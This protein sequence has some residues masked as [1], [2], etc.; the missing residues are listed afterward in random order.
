MTATDNPG[1]DGDH[2]HDKIKPKVNE[3][4]AGAPNDGYDGQ[5][6]STGK[7]DGGDPFVWLTP[8]KHVK[9]SHTDG[10]RGQSQPKPS[11][12]GDNSVWLTPTSYSY[13]KK[14]SG[15]ATNDGYDGDNSVWLTPTSHTRVVHGVPEKHDGSHSVWLTPDKSNG[16]HWPTANTYDN[17]VWLTPDHTVD[18]THDHPENGDNPSNFAWLSPHKHDGNEEHDHGDP[19]HVHHIH[20]HKAYPGAP[21]EVKVYANEGMDSD[22]DDLSCPGDGED[23]A[24]HEDVEEHKVPDH[25]KEKFRNLNYIVH[26]HK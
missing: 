5:R 8:S 1:F 9:S 10:R 22:L 14:P 26:E 12:S 15:G 6:P 13:R 2:S 24:N 19:A 11:G 21:D 18:H 25:V 7:P 3:T 4:L 17:S 23:L 20:V 16:T